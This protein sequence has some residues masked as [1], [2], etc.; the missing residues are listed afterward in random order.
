M[1]NTIII[2]EEDRTLV[3]VEEEFTISVPAEWREIEVE[4]NASR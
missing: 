3:L 4:L 1:N 2:P